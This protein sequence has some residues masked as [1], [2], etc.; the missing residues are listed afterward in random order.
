M[1]ATVP[2]PATTAIRRAPKSSRRRALTAV[3]GVVGI[4]VLVAVIEAVSRAGLVNERFLPAFSTVLGNVFRLF[5]DPAFLSGSLGSTVLTW[6]LGLL[7]ATII[8]VP[9]GVL[10]GM[11]SLA[12]TAT[13]SIIELVRPMPAVALIPLALLILGQGIEMKLAIALFA[14]VW[15]ILFNTIY[16]V[17]GVDQKSQDMARVFGVSRSGVVWRVIIPGSAP[18]IATGV[19]ISSSI[20]LIVLITVELIAGAADGLGAFIANSQAKGSVPGT[21]DVYSGIVIAGLVGL[22]INTMMGW[23]ERRW[24]GWDLTTRNEG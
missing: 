17:R 9:V 15:P 7:M 20:M 12:Y 21:I 22:V 16:G 13:R 2:G 23:A 6:F 11:S 24:F 8:A 10:L 5:G 19:R 3:F 1:T 4:L 14:S 18:F